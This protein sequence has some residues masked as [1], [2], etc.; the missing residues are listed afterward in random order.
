MSSISWKKKQMKTWQFL[1][2]NRP[3]C[4]GNRAMEGVENRS[5]INWINKQNKEPDIIKADRGK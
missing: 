5:K 4:T 2:N 3:Q 1:S